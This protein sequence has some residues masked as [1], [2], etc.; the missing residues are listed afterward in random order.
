MDDLGVT[1][2]FGNLQIR[3]QQNWLEQKLRTDMGGSAPPS[4]H[5]AIALLVHH[6]RS[7]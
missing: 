5:C 4:N 6:A 1:S 7:T 2:I 3:L